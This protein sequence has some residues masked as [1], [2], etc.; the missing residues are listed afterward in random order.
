M[1]GWINVAGE[2][3]YRAKAFQTL[4]NSADG[5]WDNLDTDYI[6]SVYRVL[7]KVNTSL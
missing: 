5:W 4:T 1:I 6:P 2:V 3:R 7:D